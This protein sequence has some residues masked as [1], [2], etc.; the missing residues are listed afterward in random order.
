MGLAVLIIVVGTVISFMLL[1]V[2]IHSDDLFLIYQY[3]DLHDC[4]RC[5]P[6]DDC[7]IKR[8]ESCTLRFL[9]FVEWCDLL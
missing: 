3:F 1:V 5:I 2:L 7:W 6:Y 9:L 8:G 4:E